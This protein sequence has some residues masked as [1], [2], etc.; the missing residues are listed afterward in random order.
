MAA[1][2]KAPT[3]RVCGRS[4]V[5]RPA[6]VAVA[7]RRPLVCRADGGYLGS[8]TNI[9]MIA[10]TTLFLSAARFGLAPTANRNATAGLKLV[11]KGN[12]VGLKSNDPDGFTVVDVLTYGAVGHLVGVGT[13][14]GLRAIGGL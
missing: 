13:V 12:A 6:K 4:S 9:I 8:T 2:L 7:S 1:S 14:L 3:A 5:A 10:S 11:E